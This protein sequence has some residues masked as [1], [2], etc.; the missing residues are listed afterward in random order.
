MWRLLSRAGVWHTQA[1][2]RLGGIYKARSVPIRPEAGSR[3]LSVEAEGSEHRS[4]IFAGIR[5]KGR[6][7]VDHDEVVGEGAMVGSQHMRLQRHVALALQPRDGIV[8]RE[9]L[10]FVVGDV[11]NRRQRL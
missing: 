2:L 9:P 5:R 10:L 3:V 7:G 4:A 6:P 11:Q 1:T 8:L